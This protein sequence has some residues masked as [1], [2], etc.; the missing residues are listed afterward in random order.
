MRKM[1]RFYNVDCA[2]CAQKIQ[3]LILKIDGVRACVLNF[4]AQKMVLEF[5]LSNKERI[6]SEITTVAKTIAPDFEIDM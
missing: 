3:E 4:L 5:D 2:H 6:M 1:Y